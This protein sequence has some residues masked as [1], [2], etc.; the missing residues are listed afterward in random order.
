MQ[1]FMFSSLFTTEEVQYNNY[2]VRVYINT[3]LK[4]STEIIPPLQLLAWFS[5]TTNSILCSP[6]G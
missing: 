4:C 3:E 6:R 1:D 2:F 5:G